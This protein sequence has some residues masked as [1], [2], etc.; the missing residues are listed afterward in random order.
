LKDDKSPYSFV[1]LPHRILNPNPMPEAPASRTNPSCTDSNPD[2]P[3]DSEGFFCVELS[4]GQ[5]DEFKEEY[6]SRPLSA[7]PVYR[8]A[9]ENPNQWENGRTL[10][11]CFFDG[12]ADIQRRVKEIASEWM[13]YANI[14]FQ[15]VEGREVEIVSSLRARAALAVPGSGKIICGLPQKKRPCLW[16]WD[17]RDQS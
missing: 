3:S 14:K 5:S 1:V 17:R 13:R 6:E 12:S 8:L 16:L 4:R 7:A 15:F 11:V 9:L 10:T 2:E